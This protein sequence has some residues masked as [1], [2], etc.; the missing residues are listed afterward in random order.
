ML[1]SVDHVRT[2]VSEELSA[3]IIRVTKIGEL[4][5]TL[6]LTSNR[7]TLLVFLGSVRRVLVTASGVRKVA[8]P[9]EKTEITTVGDPPR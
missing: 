5:T 3:S 4:G 7:Q 2:D 9:V 1:R 6:A 8:A